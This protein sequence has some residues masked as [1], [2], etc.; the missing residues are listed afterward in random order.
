MKVFMPIFNYIKSLITR[1][2]Y[3]EPEKNDSIPDR[4][5]IEKITESQMISSREVTERLLTVSQAAKK[6]EVTR[7]AIFFAIK[8]KRLN[9]KKENGTWL[10]AESDLKDY[11]ENKYCRSKSR[12]EG[13]LIF[14]K[15][16]GFYSIAEAADYLGKNTN[17]IYYLV[18]MG[19]LKSHRQG[20]AIVIKDI[21]LHNYADFINKKSDKDMNV[22]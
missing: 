20:S 2:L 4:K 10:I 6:N 16:K 5:E 8:M 3:K 14:D 22:L 13:E 18:R 15:S 12:N 7:Q 1:T 17:H 9:A 21:E 19:K 11:L